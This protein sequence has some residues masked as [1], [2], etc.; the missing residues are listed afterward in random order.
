[1]AQPPKFAALAALTLLSVFLLIP[2]RAHAA[3]AG[4]YVEKMSTDQQFNYASGA[5]DMLA[6]DLSKSDQ[7]DKTK[8]LY[9]WFYRSDGKSHTQILAIFEKHPELPAVGILRVLAKRQC[10]FE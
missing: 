3:S 5:I 2:G 10:G 1:M 7:G 8:C 6:Y 4:D 9:D